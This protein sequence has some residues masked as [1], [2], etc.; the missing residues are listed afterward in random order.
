M[1][2]AHYA[3]ADLQIAFDNSKMMNLLEKRA[4]FLK[5]TKFDKAN[6]VEDEMT[7]YK[8]DNLENLFMP[9]VFY[10]TFHT[11]YGYFVSL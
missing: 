5:A 11:E 4:N 2:K 9:K 10:A 8:D 7:K 6:E 1:D 3:I